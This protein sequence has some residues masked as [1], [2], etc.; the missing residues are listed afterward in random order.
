M[1]KMMEMYFPAFCV[2]C[3]NPKRLRF[4]GGMVDVAVILRNS[5]WEKRILKTQQDE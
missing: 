2:V 5:D 4:P 1:I 3:D